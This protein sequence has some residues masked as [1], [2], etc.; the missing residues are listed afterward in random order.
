M[1][2]APDVGQVAMDDG[3][4]SKKEITWENKSMQEIWE[5]C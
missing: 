4:F 1:N 2:T 3:L 5:M